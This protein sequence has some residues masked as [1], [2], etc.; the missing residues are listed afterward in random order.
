MKRL[1]SAA[2]LFTVLASTTYSYGQTSVVQA[3]VPFPFQV[4]ETTMPAG[5]YILRESGVLL[6]VRGEAGKPAVMIL[7]SPTEHRSKSS[8]SSLA[9]ERY[10]SDYF[11][12]N[13]REGG[14]QNGRALPKS[15]REKELARRV[16]FGHTE[17]V[18]LQTNSH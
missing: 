16:T 6:T 13:I 5:K 8:R 11:L 7:T 12:T 18:A 17:E 10:D 14:S 9:F 1:I 4:G 15:K 2:G 3:D